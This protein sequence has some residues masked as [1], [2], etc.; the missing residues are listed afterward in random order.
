MS[1]LSTVVPCLCHIISWVLYY[2]TCTSCSWWIAHS[3]MHSQSWGWNTYELQQSIWLTQTHHKHYRSNEAPGINHHAADTI[4]LTAS[5][6]QC[7][8]VGKLT[9]TGVI[10]ILSLKKYVYLNFAKRR[11]VKHN[12]TSYF[13]NRK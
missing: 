9:F 11:S 3:I 10:Y 8:Q 6:L 2:I 1:V 7:Y 12:H 5:W 13:K 4:G